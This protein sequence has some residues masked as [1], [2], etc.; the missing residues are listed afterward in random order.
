MVSPKR[1]SQSSAAIT[2]RRL[3]ENL[4]ESGFSK[5]PAVSDTVQRNSTGQ[6]QSAAAG[7]ALNVLRH[8]DQDFFSHHLDTRGDVS[9]MLVT[10]R[11]TF[12]VVGSRAEV[13]WI[14]GRC[15]EEM[16]F[17][18]SRFTEQIDKAMIEGL[19]RRMVKRKVA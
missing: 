4:F 10:P 6:T 12:E 13:R 14:T 11:Q 3:N 8:P 18:T 5:N 17:R 16:L 15:S 2:S 19:G 9:V 7:L 1:G